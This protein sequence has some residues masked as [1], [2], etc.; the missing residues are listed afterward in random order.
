MKT[1]LTISLGL[2]LLTG[3]QNEVNNQEMKQTTT[4]PTVISQPQETTYAYNQ[5][6]QYVIDNGVEIINQLEA[7]ADAIKAGQEKAEIGL[8]FVQ[9]EMKRDGLL[10]SMAGFI[11]PYRLVLTDYFNAFNSLSFGDDL[12]EF[13]E[14]IEMAKTGKEEFLY[15]LNNR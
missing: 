4:Q 3:C 8:L 6:E 15:I 12:G 7:H 1:L 10:D 11:L 9:Q 2:L 14:S 5:T 13:N